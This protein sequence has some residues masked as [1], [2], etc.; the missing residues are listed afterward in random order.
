VN[1]GERGLTVSQPTTI[2]I[3]DPRGLAGTYT[4]LGLSLYFLFPK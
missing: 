4:T 2:I 1:V 3:D